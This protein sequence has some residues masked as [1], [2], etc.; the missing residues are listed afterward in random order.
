[1]TKCIY[2]GAKIF[3]MNFAEY[4]Y[5]IIG[6]GFYGAVIAERIA[7]NLHKKVLI[8]EKN[9]HISG[10]C[11]SEKDPQT[12]IEYHKYGTHI[13]H[14][15]NP[16][17]YEYITR[18]CDFNAYYHQVL[19]MHKNKVYQ[20]PI[21]LE[22]INSYFNTNL[23][24]FE[25]KEFIQQKIRENPPGRED[26]FENAAIKSI[27]KELYEAFIKGYTQKQW[28][29]EPHLLPSSII[30]RL[31]VRTN[32]NE[33]YFFDH[34]QGI[35]IKEFTN[36]FTQ[37]LDHENITILLNTD[38]FSIRHEIPEYIKTIYTGPIDK[39]FDYCYGQLDWRSLRFEH[40]I[41]PF[42]DF[43][44]T[45]VMN[46]ADP[47][48]LYTRIHEP[49]HLHAERDYTKSHTLI[50]K[51]YSLSDNNN[52]YYPI[53]DEHNKKILKKYQEK[54]ATLEKVIIGGRLGDYKYYDM[55]HTIEKALYTYNTR[56]KNEQH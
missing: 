11:Y 32:Y 14:T 1:M 23:K 16:E 12:G 47:E 31:P 56:I 33:S 30:K 28:G 42:E 43:Q 40:E 26:N 6:S 22:T 36:I 2:L 18:F 4:D 55:H 5:L 9:Y 24:P 21:N 51:E 7:N 19:T 20:M 49:R 34:W 13:F 52:P 25:V 10:N 3:P 35:P 38:Y 45:S 8:V 37:M 53:S 50:I 46:Y 48:I 27:G 17:V 39:Y 54:A 29:K 15:S 41:I 44:G